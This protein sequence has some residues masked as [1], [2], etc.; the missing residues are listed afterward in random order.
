MTIRNN[1][2]TTICQLNRNMSYKYPTNKSNDNCDNNSIGKYKWNRVVLGKSVIHE[3][4]LFPYKLIKEGDLII[5]YLGNEIPR[6][7]FDE[8]KINSYCMELEDR[9]I[10]ASKEGSLARFINHACVANAEFRKIA[11]DGITRVGVYA[12]MDISVIDEITCRYLKSSEPHNK[13][14][15]RCECYEGCNRWLL[16]I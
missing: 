10:N 13:N 7:Q 2:E 4:G 9:I 6:A 1:P 5:E 16:R 3:I 15:I 8:S 11:V 12:T 14:S